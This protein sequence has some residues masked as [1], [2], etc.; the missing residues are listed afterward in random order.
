MAADAAGSMETTI[1]D[2]AKFTQALLSGDGL[3][4]ESHAQMLSVQIPIVSKVEFPTF[5]PGTTEEYKGIQLS[6]GLG[7]GLYRTPHRMGVLQGR[8]RRGMAGLR[9]VPSG[10]G[11]LYGGDDEQQ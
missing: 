8:P 3:S 10:A 2:Y 5:S 7:V 6:Y 4:K 9:R 11:D 1:T